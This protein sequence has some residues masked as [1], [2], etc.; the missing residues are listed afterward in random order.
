MYKWVLAV[1]ALL[2]VLLVAGCGNGKGW[3]AIITDTH[4]KPIR[5]AKICVWSEPVDPANPTQSVAAIGHA[6]EQGQIP[7]HG[8]FFASDKKGRVYC[9]GFPTGHQEVDSY[10]PGH[11]IFEGG[12]GTVHSAW[13]GGRWRHRDVFRGEHTA[14]VPPRV[15]VHWKPGDWLAITIT[16]P[17]YQPYHFAFCPDTRNGDLGVI[18]LFNDDHAT[19]REL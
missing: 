10:T 12:A 7:M 1:L 14:Y 16:A 18:Q 2:T 5:H 9:K 13:E 6:W 17:G 4:G 3:T 19:K 11:V 8:W 15:A